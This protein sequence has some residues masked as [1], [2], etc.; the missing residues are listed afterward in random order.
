MERNEGLQRKRFDD[1][2]VAIGRQ[3][4]SKNAMEEQI[5]SF[6]IELLN[7]IRLLEES[8]RPGWGRRWCQA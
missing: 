5:E 8:A 7:K 1:K 6:T 4:Q 3:R 2:R